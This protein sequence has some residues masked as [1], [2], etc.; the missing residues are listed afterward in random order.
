MTQP[1]S[2]P[3]VPTAAFSDR[4]GAVAVVLVALLSSLL[5]LAAQ[6]KL[7]GEGLVLRSSWYTLS[8]GVPA[9][10]CLLLRSARDRYAWICGAVLGLL[11][12]GMAAHSAG[13]C[14]GS[15][16]GP[17]DLDCGSIFKPYVL[18]LAAALFML[19]PFLQVWR[20]HSRRLPYDALYHRAWDNAQALAAAAFFTLA[21]WAILWL[22]AAL[23]KLIGIRFFSELFGE[24]HFFY[25]VSGLLWGLGTVL[26]RSQAG[27]LR[28]LLRVCLAL[29]RLLLPLISLVA[30]MFLAALLF[31]GLQ[32]LWDT[33]RATAL[34]LCLVFGTVALVN[35]VYQEGTADASYGRFGRGLVS[36]ALLTLPVYA[37]IAAIALQLRVGQHG[38]SVDRLWAAILIGFALL[39]AGGYAVAVLWRGRHW[40]ARLAPVNTA[41]ALLL[42]AVLLS[43]QSPLLDLR[44]LSLRSQLAQAGERLDQLDLKYLRWDLGQPGVEA[45]HGLLQDSRV[46]ADPLLQA[47]VE[48]A[49]KMESR[50]EE[51][52]ISLPQMTQR[53]PARPQG[54]AVPQGLLDLL[55]TPE[56]YRNAD[57]AECMVPPARC[58]LVSVDLDSDGAAE[59][60]L[61]SSE[62]PRWLPVFGGKGPQW[63]RV[64]QLQQREDASREIEAQ[65]LL[66]AIGRGEFKAEQAPWDDLVVE[67]RRFG[68]SP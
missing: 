67:G 35:S 48:A 12:W 65:T 10:L 64:G 13:A 40:L 36:A 56:E 15:P 63:R 14:V 4:S 62:S 32:P 3:E 51:R 6:Q 2:S 68:V 50:W 9:M 59:W 5:L 16:G 43:T 8:L 11:F 27:A 1:A 19:L 25:P 47:R 44:T 57:I 33:R 34:L 66:D 54:T 37:V 30:L 23:F 31:T 24:E 38:W 46:R 26:A 28:S 58:Y 7:I 53:L 52:P 20:E 45:L 17:S 41:V 39:Y 49:L 61:V 18:A 29:G 21:G 60:V 55:A 22:W 42:V